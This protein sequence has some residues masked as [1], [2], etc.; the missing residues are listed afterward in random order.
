LRFTALIV[1]HDSAPW[2]ERLLSSLARHLDPMPQ[3]VVVDSGSRDDGAALARARG[4]TVVAL[5]GNPGFGTANVEGLRHATEPVTVLINPDCE[6]IDD[7]LVRLARMAGERDVLLAPRL[8]NDDGTVQRS[9]HPPPGR[10]SGLVAA[11][12]PPRALPRQAREALEPWRAGQ[13]R[14]VGW[15]I[16]ACLVAKTDLLRRLGPFDP[17]AFLFYEDLDLCLRARAAGVPVELRPEI[18]VRHAGAHATGP[19]LGEGLD[20]QAR[21][22][23]EVVRAHLGDRALALDDAAQ[24]LTFAARAAVGRHRERNLALLRALR[25]ARFSAGD[26]DQRV[27]TAGP[28]P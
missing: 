4:A 18:V 27:A 20:L 19:A 17:G 23:R 6:A 26:G 14:E 16:A 24:A 22:R 2:L 1:I 13:H 25:R 9:A 21:R 15:A 5:D 7:G 10:P 3:L 8:L 12:V 11:I 28:A